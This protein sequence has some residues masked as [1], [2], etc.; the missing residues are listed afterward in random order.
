[1]PFVNVMLKGRA[2]TGSIGQ[3][4]CAAVFRRPCDPEKKDARQCP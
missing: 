2:Y 3:E 1:M 4:K